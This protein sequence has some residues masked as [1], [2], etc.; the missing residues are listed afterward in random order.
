MTQVPSRIAIIGRGQNSNGSGGVPLLPV[1]R[2]QGASWLPGVIKMA[3]NESPLHSKVA[4]SPHSSMI[5]LLQA[6]GNLDSSML[7]EKGR[8]F[9]AERDM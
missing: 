9:S 6:S 5:T 4:T 2:K 8:L 7:M 1:D 3:N